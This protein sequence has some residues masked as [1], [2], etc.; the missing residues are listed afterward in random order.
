M[1]FHWATSKCA[2]YDEKRQIIVLT[3]C[4]HL[5]DLNDELIKMFIIFF[6]R[7]S[8]EKEFKLFAHFTNFLLKCEFYLMKGKNSFQQDM[9]V[10]YLTEPKQ[11]EII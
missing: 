11:F 8:V 10:I 1:I 6:V 5:Y 7:S 2:I 3:R 4:R 9:T